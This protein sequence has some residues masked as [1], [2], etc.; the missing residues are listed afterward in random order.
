MYSFIDTFEGFLFWSCEGQLL[1]GA[2]K[3]INSQFKDCESKILKDITGNS[4]V[5]EKGRVS[6]SYSV[7]PFQTCAEG[8]Q[9]NPSLSKRV[10]TKKMYNFERNLQ[11]N[12][13]TFNKRNAISAF[14]LVYMGRVG[15]LIVYFATLF[16]QLNY[17]ASMI[18]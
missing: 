12:V 9:V 13:I 16:Q 1:A 6:D 3:I 15:R 5:Q 10:S 4:V 14:F 11:F 18:G 2:V 8:G 17:I 7:R